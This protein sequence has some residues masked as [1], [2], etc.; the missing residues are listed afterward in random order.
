[1][2]FQFKIPDRKF[3]REKVLSELKEHKDRIIYKN[4]IEEIEFDITEIPTNLI[5]NQD[6]RDSNEWR[7]CFYVTVSNEDE[8]NKL[9][10]NALMSGAD[11]LFLDIAKSQTDWTKLFQGIGFEYISTRI[12]T[13]DS[14]E[15]NSLDKY[16]KNNEIKNV[17]LLIDP[18]VNDNS[19]QKDHVLF[20]NGFELNQ[21]GANASQELGILL[22]SF[23]EL[24]LK[25]CGSHKFNFH[26]GIGSNYF[27]EIAKFRAIK[28][29]VKNLCYIYNIESPEI[30]F[31][32]ETGFLNKSLKDPHTNLLRQ[33]TEAMSA[34]L[35]GV[36]EL[37]IRSYDDISESG[38]NEFSR[39]MALNVSSILKEESYFDY[40]NDPLKG[41]NLVN[42]L[43]EKIIEKSWQYF[44]KL[45]NFGSINS[46]DK[47]NFIRESIEKIRTNRIDKFE[48]N[49]NQLIGINCFKNKDEK[50]ALWNTDKKYLGK[51]Y[52]ILE[53]N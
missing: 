30:V 1:M 51:S 20:L 45:E 36:A 35:G 50:L 6:E 27:I 7:N 13:S 41:S 38:S 11:S 18:L 29:L 31:T 53:K 43:T 46:Q 19:F 14:N 44:Q 22:S 4:E 5:E 25:D 17:F 49:E 40:V 33:S 42:L 15:I 24:L 47:L 34:I 23:H 2:E 12:R 3:W 9:C 28:W 52:L 8:A 48:S 10:L 21:I 16:L 39:R 26:L 32:A 37:T